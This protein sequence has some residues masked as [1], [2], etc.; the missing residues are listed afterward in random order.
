GA[1]A[2]GSCSSSRSARPR[3]PHLRRH[4]RLAS[5]ST[6]ARRRYGRGAATAASAAAAVARRGNVVHP[7]DRG[8]TWNPG[9]MSQGGVPNRTTVGAN[10]SASTLGN[11]TVDASAGIRYRRLPHPGH[12]GGPKNA[13]SRKLRLLT[14]S[15]AWQAGA[16]QS[17]PS[18]L[19]LTSR[20]A[21]FNAG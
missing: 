2:T 5:A 20:P 14:N 17:L 12:D 10:V 4:L 15:V 16:N 3:T 1:I 11:G 21:F 8:T 7:S 13:A 18:S 9:L 6:A 19:Y